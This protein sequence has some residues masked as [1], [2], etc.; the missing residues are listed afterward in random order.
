[1]AKELSPQLQMQGKKITKLSIPYI[2]R[3]KQNGSLNA[4]KMELLSLLLAA[5]HGFCE[6]MQVLLTT[7]EAD[8]NFAA[9]NTGNT[10]LH[11][12]A[13]H[14]Q[15]PMVKLLTSR[16]AKNIPNKEKQTPKDMAKA[17]QHQ[18]IYS[19]LCAIYEEPED[20]KEDVKLA[21]AD[22]NA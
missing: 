12:A 18:D 16:G 9:S 5:K 20:V 6:I 11:Y 10:A 19:F 2:E 21:G 8:I 4:T 15:L 17:N 13:H 22:D 14:G 3:M 7:G 1:M